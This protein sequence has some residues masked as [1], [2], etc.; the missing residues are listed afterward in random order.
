VN[1]LGLSELSRTVSSI[2]G[3]RVKVG[4]QNHLVGQE[5]HFS[6]THCV[7]I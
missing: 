4:G 3:P 5:N 7:Q 6:S 1:D 2:R